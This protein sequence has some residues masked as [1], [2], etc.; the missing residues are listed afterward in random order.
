M[1]SSPLALITGSAKRL[2]RVASIHLATKGY[3]LALH[4]NLSN[5]EVLLLQKELLEKGSDCEVFQADLKDPGEARL[6]LQNVEI[7]MG[8]VDLLINNASFFESPLST[9]FPLSEHWENSRSLNL[10]AP[11]LLIEYL[12]SNSQ[13]AL[14][15]NMLDTR[16]AQNKNEYFSYTLSKKA[17]EN[18]TY[19]SANALAPKIRVVGI[20]PGIL[21]PP[22]GKEWDAM[23][24]KIDNTPLAR[25]PT[26]EHFC[27]TLDFLIQTTCITGQ[28]IYLNGGEHLN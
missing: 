15:I 13:N 27:S 28:I 20:A 18:L 4:Y 16:I 19:M 9:D 24:E 17:L 26:L 3:R 25:A 23:K 22:E 14:V 21:L 8:S 1:T 7:K 2:G 12:A 11:L 6:L 10:D 5:R